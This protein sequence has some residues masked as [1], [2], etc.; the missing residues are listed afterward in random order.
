MPRFLPLLALVAFIGC[1]KA[2]PTVEPNPSGGE[3]A[4]TVP[5]A[6]AKA[7]HEM[8][9][10]KHIIPKMPVAG[11]LGGRPFIPDCVVFENKGLLFR[12]GADFVADQQIS[13]FFSDYKPADAVKLTVK[14]SEKWSSSPLPSLHVSTKSDDLPKTDF[15]LDGYALTLELAPRVDGKIPGRIYLGL[16]GADGN[17]LAGEFTATYER[18]LDE[19]PGPDD[20]PFIAGKIV[21]EGK[22]KQRLSVRY[23]GLPV[24]G[25][26]PITDGVA[27]PFDGST[28]TTIRTT[29]HAP[30]VAGVRGGKTGAEY[31]CAHLPPGK[32]FVMGRLDDGPAAWKLVDVAADS[33][34]DAPL[35]I[36]TATAGSIEVAVPAGASGQVQ[37]I[38][39]GLKF[40]DPTGTFTTAISGALGAFD[41]VAAAKATLKNLAPGKYEVSLRSGAAIHR[42]EVEVEAGKTA[43]VELK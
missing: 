30:R 2:P 34:I 3:T 21:H 28:I 37:A 11:M 35:T 32:Y 15:V 7:G 1:G 36:P 33:G 8:D 6:V 26:D 5:E 23:V 38:P 39:A 19:A 31:D 13:I 14:P 16:P 25:G 22:A 24:N 43:K 40:D 17:F 29:T 42:V 4:P 20:R 27:S 41:N 9:P 12:T 10:A 18:G